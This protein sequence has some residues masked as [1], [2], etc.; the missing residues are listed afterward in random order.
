MAGVVLR[1]SGARPTPDSE[2]FAW[3]RASL[4]GENPPI[5]EDEPQC[6]FFR[7]RLIK[8]GIVVA[9]RIYVRQIVSQLG[10][11][12]FCEVM[13]C[14]IG[15]ARFDV[16]SSWPWL[17]KN[18]IKKSEYLFLLE[19]AA[20]AKRFDKESPHACPFM[21]VDYTIVKIPP[22]PKRKRKRKK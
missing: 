5:H 16:G 10:F 2:L 4:A 1:P 7:T 15:D 13:R 6:G 12:Q 19:Q 3:W 14:E 21:P 18:P 9:S 20:W 11:L 17:C 8:G 22:M